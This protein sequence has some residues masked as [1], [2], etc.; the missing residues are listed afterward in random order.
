M[1]SGTQFGYVEGSFT[2]SA[3]V[4]VETDEPESSIQI[5]TVSV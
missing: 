2:T 4:R 3:P 1:M 5:F